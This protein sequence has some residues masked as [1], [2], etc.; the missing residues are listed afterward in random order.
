MLLKPII[1]RKKVFVLIV[2]KLL[3]LKLWS[4]PKTLRQ[5]MLD[6]VKKGETS[7]CIMFRIRKQV[8]TMFNS[9]V[10][11]ERIFVRDFFS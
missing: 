6:K 9:L 8:E 10:E 4:L 5:N 11:E 3:T 7:F 1:E 2:K